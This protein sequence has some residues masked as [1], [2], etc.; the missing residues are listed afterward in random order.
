MKAHFKVKL[1][2]QRFDG[3]GANMTIALRLTCKER[4]HYTEI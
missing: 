1:T 2:V 3:M 4:A